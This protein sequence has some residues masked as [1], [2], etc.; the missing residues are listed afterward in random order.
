MGH[1]YV[2]DLNDQVDEGLCSL[3]QAV[4]VHLQSNCYPPIHP[5]MLPACM[6][7]I[8]FVEEDMPGASVKLPDGIRLASRYMGSE[9]TNLPSAIRVVEACHLEAFIQQEED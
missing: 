2:S 4:M 8:Q 9:Y 5:A 1:G 3:E 7:A 6:E